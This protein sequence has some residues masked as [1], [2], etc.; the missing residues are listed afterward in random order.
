MPYSSISVRRLHPCYVL[1]TLSKV[2]NVD[3]LLFLRF[4]PDQADDLLRLRSDP[5]YSIRFPDILRIYAQRWEPGSDILRQLSGIYGNLER[6]PDVEEQKTLE[7]HWELHRCLEHLDGQLQVSHT[8]DSHTGV[9]NT[10][11]VSYR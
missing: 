6:D 7:H 10:W 9:W 1:Y 4:S 8:P 11:M 3:P 2:R 5:F